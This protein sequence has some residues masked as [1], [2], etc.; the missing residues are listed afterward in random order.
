MRVSVPFFAALV[1]AA[2]VAL[3]GAARA[4]SSSIEDVQSIVIFMQEN[5]AFDHYYGT[6]D[7]VGGSNMRFNSP[8]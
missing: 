7:G 5:R 8:S 1:C 2:V 6:L 3:T 4:A